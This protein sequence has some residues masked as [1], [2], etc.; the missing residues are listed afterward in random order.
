VLQDQEKQLSVGV[1]EHPS[2]LR[3]A[4]IDTG[5]I[6]GEKILHLTFTQDQLAGLLA[7]LTRALFEMAA[8]TSEKRSQFDHLRLHQEVFQINPN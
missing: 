2:G 7:C 5:P 4:F 6:E 8:P 3:L 1:E